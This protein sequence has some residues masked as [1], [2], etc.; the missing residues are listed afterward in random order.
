VLTIKDIFQSAYHAHTANVLKTEHKG[1]PSVL[2]PL[3]SEDEI[4]IEK[5]KI[6]KSP[7]PDG[8]LEVLI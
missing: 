8:I 1:E 6:Y 4:M 3:S 7:D 2:K 5:S